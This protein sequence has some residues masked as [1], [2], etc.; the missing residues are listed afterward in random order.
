MGYFLNGDNGTPQV[1][2]CFPREILK[3]GDNRRTMA[4][5]H[6]LDP[7]VKCG[8][9]FVYVFKPGTLTTEGQ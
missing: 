1:S 4:V 7:Y 3:K 9:A 8:D 2:L 6:K 5:P